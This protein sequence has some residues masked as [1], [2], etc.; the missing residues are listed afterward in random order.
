MD[1]SDSRGVVAC[2]EAG[3]RRRGSGFGFPKRGREV[4]AKERVAT[5]SLHRAGS[6]RR[7]PRI[8]AWLSPPS[9]PDERLAQRALLLNLILWALVLVPGPYLAY[10]IAARPD[11]LRRAL[12]QSAFGETVNLV[13][14]VVL[15]RGHVAIASRAQVACFWVFFLATAWTSDGTRSEAYQM[16]FPLV[17]LL[18]GLLVSTK[19]AILAAAA[20]LAAGVALLVH[21]GAGATPLR[22]Q[23]LTW[24]VSLC[25]FPVTAVLQHL[26]AGLIRSSLDAVE[27]ANARIREL[28]TDLE[29]RVSDRTAELSAANRELEA[30]SS[31]VSHDLRAPLRAIS[32]FSQAL[33]DDEALSET[34]SQSLARIRA[35]SSRMDELIR[36]LLDLSR[37]TKL[38]L[39]RA[40]VDVSSLAASIAAEL[41]RAEPAR[42]V[43]LV[44]APDL[45]ARADATLLRIVLTNLM[46]NAWKFTSRTP[47]ARVEVGSIAADPPVY[48]VRD[49]G[50]GF[51]MKDA[52]L[53]FV[54][55]K[56][57]HSPRDF[58]GTGVGLATVQ[59]VVAR[60]G[61]RVWAESAK[62][63][64]ATFFFTLESAGGD[65][66]PAS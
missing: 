12:I 25:F 3:R 2:S 7:R 44:I 16:G 18:A 34:G 17:I 64:G 13:L 36:A 60:H 63:R 1:G 22:D 54:A 8:P 15:R 11:Q 55:F 28:N 61:G 51:D 66:S 4:A 52:A 47:R 48:F 19:G 65:R 6:W 56:R 27:K 24:V 33:A 10:V 5:A 59:R 26:G 30:F 39:H 57:L 49:N 43:E 53:L 35:A 14:L 38:E 20:S 50:A 9:L 41:A 29:R 42:E 21:A 31:A 37:I 23:V 58:S 45:H 62:D 40:P 32:G 46:A